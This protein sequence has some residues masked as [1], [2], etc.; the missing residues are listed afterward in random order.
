M[1]TKIIRSKVCD[2]CNS[3]EGVKTY[4][5]G[6]VGNGRG[7]APDLC[8]IHQKPIEEA[9]EAVPA[10]RPAGGLRKQPKVK[11]EAEVRKLRKPRK[12]P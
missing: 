11:T 2:M 4:R 5:I 9:M 6:I 12:K 10:S 8:E 1:A 7:V 3:D